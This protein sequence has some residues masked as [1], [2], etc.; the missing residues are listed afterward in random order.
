MTLPTF[1]LWSSPSLRYN[2]YRLSPKG[3]QLSPRPP[4]VI[5]SHQVLTIIPDSLLQSPHLLPL[6]YLFLVLFANRQTLTEP[7]H[8]ISRLGQGKK[9]FDREESGNKG[10]LGSVGKEAPTELKS[11]TGN[12]CHFSTFSKGDY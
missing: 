10:K 1:T 5:S 7:A 12:L 8:V 9:V 11:L 3:T 4:L 2:C 6:K